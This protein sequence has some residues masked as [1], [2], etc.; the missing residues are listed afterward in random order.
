MNSPKPGH[1]AHTVW[2]L[3]A[4]RGLAAGMVVYAH[5][6]SYAN[7]DIALLRFAYT[8]VDLFFVLS[9]FLF[10]PYLLGRKLVP[11]EFAI[12]R[13]F[14]I[15]PAYLA[16][17]ALYVGMK[18]GSGL[19]VLY[20]W[21]HLVFAQLQSREMTFFYNPAFWSLPAEVEFYLF[22]PLMAVLTR[23]RPGRFA[24]LVGAAL[25]M[26]I[27]LAHFADTGLQNPAYIAMH[28]L[29]G[30]LVEFLLGGLAWQVSEKWKSRKLALICLGLGVAGWLLLADVFAR[31]GDHGLN[32]TWLR[33]QISWLAALSF[34]LMLPAVLALASLKPPEML[35]GVS[36][37]AGRLSYGT[38]LLH[39]AL[40][41]LVR[42]HVPFLGA[43]AG[44][45]TAGVL[46]LACSW[47]LYQFWENPWRGFG[48]SVAWRVSGWRRGARPASAS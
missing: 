31:L 46:T 17:L 14:R 44:V 36:V 23:G 34:A 10:S 41:E 15:Y 43:L 29:P 45:L 9:G 35:M 37:W 1:E 26:R 4:L 39:F 42:Q 21:E 2:S 27:A 32:A 20:V 3:E 22:L 16:A 8:G 19:P 38:Y 5:Y 40:L 11:L 28:H 12:R 6:A 18:A 30:M 48:R 24:V 13:A 33:N 25:G 47:L 7:I